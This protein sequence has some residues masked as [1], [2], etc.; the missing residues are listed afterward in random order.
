MVPSCRVSQSLLLTF[1]VLNTLALVV[2]LVWISIIFY[3]NK[4]FQPL[5]LLSSKGAYP[6]LCS[7]S[8]PLVLMTFSLLTSPTVDVVLDFI[9]WSWLK[10]CRIYLAYSLNVE[11]HQ[12]C[13]LDMRKEE[14]AHAHKISAVSVPTVFIWA[15]V[16]SLLLVHSL[17]Y[18]IYLLCASAGS[19]GKFGLFSMQ[20]KHCLKRSHGLDN[21]FS[22][23]FNTLISLGWR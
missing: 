13:I 1:A 21:N 3:F 14:D 15:D 16:V 12:D 17:Y 22:N 18:S 19:Q 2:F 20:F 11:A 9:I 8:S 23:K 7:F 10:Q 6:V 5:E 4:H